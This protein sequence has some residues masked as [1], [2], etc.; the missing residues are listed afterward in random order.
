MLSAEDELLLFENGSH[1]SSTLSTK[2]NRTYSKKLAKEQVWLY[3]WDYKSN[4]NEKKNENEK[5]MA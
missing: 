2:K 3:S 5:Y 4:H 1:S